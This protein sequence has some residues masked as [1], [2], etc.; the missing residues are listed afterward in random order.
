MYWKYSGIRRS[1]RARGI[2]SY[3]LFF[4]AKAYI[5][6]ILMSSI[7]TLRNTNIFD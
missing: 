1:L 3:H 6:E 4:Q 7:E 5:S 2:N